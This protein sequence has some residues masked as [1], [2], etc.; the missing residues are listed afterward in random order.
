MAAQ[1]FYNDNGHNGYASQDSFFFEPNSKTPGRHKDSDEYSYTQMSPEP[2]IFAQP[3]K[4]PP[5]TSSSDTTP[6]APLPTSL[7][8]H[9]K[10]FSNRSSKRSSTSRGLSIHQR[11][12]RERVLST[13][14]SEKLLNRLIDEEYDAKEAKKLLNAALDQLALYKSS[15]EQLAARERERAPLEA[16]KAAI[17][18]ERADLERE[19]RET[20]N[21][22]LKSVKA[23]MDAQRDTGKAKQELGEMKMKMDLL[24]EEL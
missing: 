8:N 19:R 13:L 21:D 16:E 20:L 18:R 5:Q 10:D 4:P 11:R 24:T 2:L 7:T 1:E 14:P 3:T 6:P 22:G 12:E 17:A 23:V 9:S 15:I